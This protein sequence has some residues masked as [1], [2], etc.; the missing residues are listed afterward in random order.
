MVEPSSQ[1][2][3]GKN[4]QSPRA[5]SPIQSCISPWLTPIAYPLLRHGVVPTFFGDIKITG[6]ENIPLR[7]PV[8]LAPTHRS[9]WDSLILPYATGRHVTG[10]DLRFM[11]TADEMNGLQGWFIR[12]LGGFPINPRQPAIASLR[13]GMEILRK[14]EMMVIFPEGAI[15]RDRHIHPLRPGLSRLAIQAE[16]SN[17]SLGVKIVPIDLHYCDP[18]PSW[19]TDVQIKIG[20][21]LCVRDYCLP[22][23]SLKAR[24]KNLT[25]SLTQA[26]E[27]LL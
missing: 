10:R 7:G 9:R 1:A 13:L 23:T 15:F 22:H 19:G 11:V 18:I 4:S 17:P 8:I 26:L 2:I 16:T 20:H 21:P 3:H 12:Q 5:I 14:Q 6:Q 27:D 24:A 25:V